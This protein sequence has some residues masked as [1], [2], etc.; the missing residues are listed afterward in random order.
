MSDQ[1]I[2]RIARELGF[3]P[4]QAEAAAALLDDGNTVPFITRYRKEATGG[5]DEEQLRRLAERLAYL[6]G[7]EA[8]REEVRAALEAGGNLTAELAAALAGAETLQAVEDI[9]LPFRPKRRTRAQ[10]ARELGLQPLAE[11]ILA[12]GAPATRQAAAAPFLGEQ[13]P[14][15]AAALAGA[16]DI[17]AEQVA[18]TASVRQSVR[19]ATRRTASLRVARKEGA[20]DEKGTYQQYY[21]FSQPL[22]A[23]P[24]HR[25]LAINRGEREGVLAVDLGANHEAFVASL[26]RRYA[27]GGS[28][29]DDEIRAAVADGYKRLLAP[30]VERDLRA[31][32]TTQAEQHA[33]TI[34]AANLRRLLLQPPLRDR[35][36][37]GVDPGFRTGCKLAVVDATG[38]YL[39]GAL[40]Y[41]HQ[42]DRAREALL[43][44]CQKWGVQVIAIGNGTASRET[45][46]LV[47]EVI[48]AAAVDEERKTKDQGLA[49]VDEG[50]KAKDERRTP[51]SSLVLRPSALQYVIVSEAGASV[52]SASEAARDEFPTLDATERGNISIARRLQDP[53]AELVKIDPKALGIG[54]YQ[55]DVDQKALAARLEA[56]VE[57]AVNYVGVD[58]NTASAALLTHVAGLTSKTAKAIVAHRDAGGPFRARR[59]LKKV[60]GLGPKAFE[61][62]AGFLRI[63]S[64]SD[65]LDGTAIHP[66]SYEA[67]RLLIARFDGDG[68]SKLPEI[69]AR[70]QGAIGRGEVQLS[71]L[72]AEL[73]VGQPTI[74]D[75]IE[76]M[77]RPGRDPRDELPPP[78]LRADVL[79][80]EDLQPGMWLKGTVRNVVDFGA[81]VD[82]GVKN[83]GL[84][85]VSE[86]ADRFVKNPLEVVQVGD[87]VDVRVLSV[88]LARGRVALS[89]RTG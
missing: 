5:L 14:D 70:I 20:A 33:L 45:E 39:E 16:R 11:Q 29:M 85:H 18:E 27:P 79:K 4:R 56:V 63:P 13:V 30:A 77:A 51:P 71:R 7:L 47:A 62:A 19:E 88:D 35:V 28:W 82:I 15:A 80:L 44:L 64:A 73:G 72:A 54:M 75:I 34:F 50:R 68:A 42:P 12:H 37:L 24:P 41:L 81:F 78:M 2:L 55:H 65:P 83:D 58:L 22:A 61:Q 53:L 74:A 52:Y 6:R 57:S 36:V 23:L 76:Y 48:R 69:A 1:I 32:L 8:R 59:E 89:M 17:I 49:A 43:R 87:L 46:A 9:Y 25:V 40:I 66:E 26:Q 31:E 60:K 84:V 21:D 10:A 86:L 67:A 38:K 3:Q